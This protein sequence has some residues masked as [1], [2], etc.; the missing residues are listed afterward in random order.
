[1]EETDLETKL[2]NDVSRFD[3]NPVKK[4]STEFREPA[5]KEREAVEVSLPISMHTGQIIM[6]TKMLLQKDLRF[7]DFS[8]GAPAR[9][10][11]SDQS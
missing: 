9:C 4:P 7:Y 6:L 3:S 5:N 1:M 10:W 8:T 2:R 11:H